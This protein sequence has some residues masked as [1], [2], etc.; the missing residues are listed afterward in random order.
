MKKNKIKN[1][2]TFWMDLNPRFYIILKNYI[3][4]MI[5]NIIYKMIYH[6]S[7]DI[8]LTKSLVKLKILFISFLVLLL[9]FKLQE[10]STNL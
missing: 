9:T 6:K 4:K 2:Y 10:V 3:S 8:C 5:S 1:I 7:S